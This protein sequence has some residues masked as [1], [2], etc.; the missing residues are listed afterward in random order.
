MIVGR[1][2]T[3]AERRAS[4]RN[5]GLFNLVNGFS[6]MCLGDNVVILLC[7]HLAAPNSVVAVIGSM[8]YLG[9]LALPLGVRRTAK[10]GA[11]ACQADFWICRNIAALLIATS[12]LV[13][14]LSPPVAWG[15]VLTGSFLF[16]ACR[17]AGCVLG[18]PLIGD[19]TTQEEAAVLNGVSNR[20]FY[21]SGVVTII[22][23]ALL[24]HWCESVWT[25]VAVIV[26]GA[27]C[28]ILAS[29]FARRI[30]ETGAVRDAARLDLYKGMR[31]SFRSRD[32]RMLSAAW[33]A[34]NLSFALI[35][36]MSALTLR[37][38][39]GLGDTAVLLSAVVLS[40]A[41]CLVS[42]LS[43]RLSKHLGPRAVLAWS[44]SAYIVVTLLWCLFPASPSPGLAFYALVALI[45]A[46]IG[47]GTLCLSNA[48]TGYFIMI[49]PDAKAQ[50]P[51]SIAVQIVSSVC[52]GVGGATL[53]SG[54]ISLAKRMAPHLG[55]AFA[56]DFGVFRLYFIMILPVVA[57]CWLQIVRLR[58]VIHEFRRKYGLKAVEH[59]M[60]LALHLRPRA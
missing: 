24:T 38:G 40:A 1:Q 13:A 47:A 59:V 45:F 27:V 52:A 11:A 33:F 54:M 55:D 6:Y 8:M 30:R 57:L 10:V 18:M 48:A 5:Y 34:I 22:A 23:I 12:V 7:V 53:A 49:C 17:A 50:V 36:P 60:G 42:P 2:L 35:A 58:T 3:P 28:G 20:N 46:I 41:G 25:L 51:G 39:C 26:F 29:G 15:V 21:G 4:Q 44:F 37:R 31:E 32:V 19:I 56:G 14:K 9:F 43:G 16:Y